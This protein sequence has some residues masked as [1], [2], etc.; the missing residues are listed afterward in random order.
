MRAELILAMTGQNLRQGQERV[1]RRSSPLVEYPSKASDGF[2]W[3]KLQ[4]GWALSAT[5]GSVTVKSG[6]VIKREYTPVVIAQD[7]MAIG[8]SPT[9]V[10]LQIKR[11][12][13][14]GEIIAVT[15]E[16]VTDGDYVKVWFYIFQKTAGGTV[17]L[18]AVNL[19]QIMNVDLT[20]YGD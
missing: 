13:T 16:P 8:T 5:A 18:I 14:D 15:S 19:G 9:Y 6:A 3:E 4:F 11:D 17:E 12:M 1:Q 7:D 10:G 20:A 2:P